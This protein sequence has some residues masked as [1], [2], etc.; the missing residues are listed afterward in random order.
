[1]HLFTTRLISHHTSKYF[2]LF[3]VEKQNGVFSVPVSLHPHLQSL[4]MC[5]R[6]VRVAW[7]PARSAGSALLVSIPWCLAGAELKVLHP[8]LSCWWDAFPNPDSLFSCVI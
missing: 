4:W 5:G 7:A 6:A 8:Q 1:M 3:E 2:L